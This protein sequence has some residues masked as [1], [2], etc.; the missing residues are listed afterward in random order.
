MAAGLVKIQDNASR[1]E[2]YSN[3]LFVATVKYAGELNGSVEDIIGFPTSAG[4]WR[5]TRMSL[6]AGVNTTHDTSASITATVE[7]NTDGGTSALDTAPVI[8]NAAGTGRKVID[9]NDSNGTGLTKAVPTTTVANSTFADSDV[10]FVTLTEAGSGGT[11][12]SDVSVVLE[13]T[14]VQDFDPAPTG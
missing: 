14:E 10:A 5:L 13:F 6:A 9:S 1:E 12:P 2:G 4:G 8:T 7:K 3:K 11:D